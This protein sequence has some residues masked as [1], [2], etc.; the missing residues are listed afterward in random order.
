MIYMYGKLSSSYQDF[1]E[2]LIARGYLAIST[3]E[4]IG[5]IITVRQNSLGW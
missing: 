1:F 4:H 2:K 3:K 5:H